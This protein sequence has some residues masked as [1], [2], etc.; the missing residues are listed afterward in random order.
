MTVEFGQ[1]ALVAVALGGGLTVAWWFRRA[2]A[3]RGHPVDVSTLAAPSSAVVFTR[4]QCSNCA[5]VLGLLEELGMKVRHIRIE[6]EQDVFER[7][8]VTAVPLTVLT[9][10]AGRAVAQFGGVP[11]S[12]VLR[13]AARRSR[14]IP[15][16]PPAGL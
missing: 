12:R 10:R 8:G 2:A 15:G 13:R 6:D 7:L 4:D 16:P 11:R 14:E 3:R 9:D 1:I 5:R